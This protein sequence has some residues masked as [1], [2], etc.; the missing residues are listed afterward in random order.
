MNCQAI[1][2]VIEL[3]RAAAS[4]GSCQFVNKL[5]Q[6]NKKQK[7]KQTHK[8]SEMKQNNSTVT[9][10]AIAQNEAHA[11]RCANK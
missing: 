7:P 8:K 3:F 4:Q 2:R 10:L 6:K 11:N 5:C 9:S 1:G